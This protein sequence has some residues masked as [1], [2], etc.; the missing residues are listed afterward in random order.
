SSSRTLLRDRRRDQRDFSF[1]LGPFA[2]VMSCCGVL[3]HSRKAHGQ[4]E[5]CQKIA[6]MT[7]VLVFR[8]PSWHIFCHDGVAAG[9]DDARRRGRRS[10]SQA[11][12]DGQ[13]L[14][15]AVPARS[16]SA[17][18]VLLLPADSRTVRCVAMRS[19]R[20]LLS[21]CPKRL[22]NR[23]VAARPA[24]SPK[25]VTVVRGGSEKAAPKMSSQPI[26]L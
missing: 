24:S 13:A 16:S 10:A 7:P 12:R 20:G 3:E 9:R 23:S 5:S 11:W 17:A 4:Q 1:G 26:T 25:A 2:Q 19:T 22:I 15:P 18:D 8:R 6:I 14:R 21:R